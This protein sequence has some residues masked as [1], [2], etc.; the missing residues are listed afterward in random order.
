MT[1]RM[2]ENRDQL[3]A[4]LFRTAQEQQIL[5]DNLEILRFDLL[6]SILHDSV[7]WDSRD[8]DADLKAS[9]V[10]LAINLCIYEGSDGAEGQRKAVKM[11]VNN[12]RICS[13]LKKY[14]L[15]RNRDEQVL[16]PPHKNILRI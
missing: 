15:G 4:K 3:F 1:R 13:T 10:S 7:T 16:F 11:V 14:I 9:A 8:F 12:E 6:A 5:C 2:Q